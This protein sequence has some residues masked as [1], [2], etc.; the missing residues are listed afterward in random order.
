[1]NGGNV[2]LVCDDLSYYSEKKLRGLIGP[3]AESYALKRKDGQKV[4]D[5]IPA[6]LVQTLTWRNVAY[7]DYNLRLLDLGEAF[8]RAKRVIKLAQPGELQAPETIFEN[9]ADYRIDLWRAGCIVG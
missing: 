2:G 6:E 8:L 7:K 4:A 9:G 1:L 3:Y 5:S